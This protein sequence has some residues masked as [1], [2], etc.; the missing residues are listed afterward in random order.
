[1]HIGD[2]C[3]KRLLY[4]EH[5]IPFT[6]RDSINQSKILWRH[7][8]TPIEETNNWKS[9]FPTFKLHCCNS[10]TSESFYVSV[11]FSE[12]VRVLFHSKRNMC[13]WYVTSLLVKSGW[14]SLML[15]KVHDTFKICLVPLLA[16]KL[17]NWR[18]CLYRANRTIIITRKSNTYIWR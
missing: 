12:Q 14:C 6:Y 5:S 7:H 10:I 15:S 1:M 4:L 11:L 17:K 9:M 8:E 18:T 13:N 16:M 2:L 3:E